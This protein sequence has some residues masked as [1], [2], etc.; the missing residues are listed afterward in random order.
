MICES[1]HG[2]GEIWVPMRFV[3]GMQRVPCDDCCGSGIA[4]CCDGLR[5]KP[6]NNFPGAVDKAPGDR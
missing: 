6:E 4:H 2:Y 1:C 5:E 3:R